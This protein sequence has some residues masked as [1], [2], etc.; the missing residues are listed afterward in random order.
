[1]PKSA[2]RNLQTR[3]ELTKRLSGWLS[4]PPLLELGV[5][6]RRDHEVIVQLET[7]L[8]RDYEVALRAAQE[9]RNEAGSMHSA[10]DARI[11]RDAL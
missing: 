6:V 2:H 4:F 8:L 7:E 1:M 10:Q 9:A 5:T 11:A 3:R